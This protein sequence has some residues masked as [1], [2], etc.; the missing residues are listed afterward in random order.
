MKSINIP[1][2]Y[3]EAYNYEM[4]MPKSIVMHKLLMSGFYVSQIDTGI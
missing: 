4:N 1:L 3:T 2:F